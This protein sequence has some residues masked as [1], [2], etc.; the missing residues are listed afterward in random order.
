MGSRQTHDWRR[1]GRRRGRVVHARTGD[2]GA[3]GNAETLRNPPAGNRRS[4]SPSAHINAVR[5]PVRVRRS[6]PD[7]EWPCRAVY[8]HPAEQRTTFG[9]RVR[10]YSP[11]VGKAREVRSGCRAEPCPSAQAAP[12]RG[13][14]LTVLRMPQTDGRCG[15]PAGRAGRSREPSALGNAAHAR[16]WACLIMGA[17]SSSD[18]T[19][20]SV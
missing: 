16:R 12:G 5:K 10:P 13:P 3:F 1:P 15:S 20:L 17:C 9:R 8:K 14:C 2:L 6:L 19:V 4:G 18:W 11:A 7:H